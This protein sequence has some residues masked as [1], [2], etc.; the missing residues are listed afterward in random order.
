MG[1]GMHISTVHK[2]AARL[3]RAGRL[4]GNGVEAHARVHK[5]GTVKTVTSQGSSAA[6]RASKANHRFVVV[7]DPGHGG[8]DSG[9]ANLGL[10]EKYL[11]LALA[12]KTA[13]QLRAAG[14]RVYLTRTTDRPVNQPFRDYIRGAYSS[15]FLTSD[16]QRDIN[17]LE[18]RVAFSNAHHADVYV[19]MHVNASSPD[20]G[21]LTLYY[22]PAHRFASANQRLAS[23][24]D[25][26]I[27]GQLHRVGYTPRNW[28]VTTDVAL[29]APQAY[30]D[31]PYFLQIGPAD[32]KDGL[33]ENKA[34]SA[35]GETLF[36]S[37]NHENQLLH[38]NRIATAIATGYTDGIERYLHSKGH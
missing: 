16:Q 13:S 33:I 29:I 11:T 35:L 18:A 7:L 28:G 19:A 21:G 2:P 15:R 3:G 23:L 17:E 25:G 37:N 34:V 22:C 38:S 26:S 30:P 9:A 4:L 36:L 24:L 14:Y 32:N 27:L 20:V 1:A 8:W 12:R 10:E 6:G 5:A 31:Y